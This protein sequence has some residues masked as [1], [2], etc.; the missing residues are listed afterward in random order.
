MY[1]R[2]INTLQAF[3]DKNLQENLIAMK[4]KIIKKVSTLHLLTIIL[5]NFHK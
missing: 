5:T 4:K 1:S 3:H 2:S